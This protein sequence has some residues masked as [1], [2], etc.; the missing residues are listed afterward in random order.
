MVTTTVREVIHVTTNINTK[1]LSIKVFSSIHNLLSDERF[2]MAVRESE[3]E[4]FSISQ[5]DVV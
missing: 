3:E 2:V 4:N 1:N 5:E